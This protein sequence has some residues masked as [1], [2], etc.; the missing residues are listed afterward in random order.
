MRA[1]FVRICAGMKRANDIIRR[2]LLDD[3]I[4]AVWFLFF[5]LFMLA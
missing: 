2:K 4:G 3:P 5:L 1:T